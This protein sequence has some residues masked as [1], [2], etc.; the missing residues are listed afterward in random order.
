MLNGLSPWIPKKFVGPKIKPVRLVYISVGCAENI[1][2]QNP[3]AIDN[4][5]EAISVARILIDPFLEK[6]ILPSK[7][8]VYIIRE[9]VSLDTISFKEYINSLTDQKMLVLLEFFTG[10]YA[11]EHNIEGLRNIN[12]VQLGLVPLFEGG[13]Y[14]DITQDH[15]PIFNDDYTEFV[16]ISKM[17]ANDIIN[18]FID[19]ID[20]HTHRLHLLTLFK[21]LKVKYINVLTYKDRRENSTYH[22]DKLKEFL[23]SLE[24]IVGS[25][26][27]NMSVN[28]ML[29]IFIKYLTKNN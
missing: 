2:Q 21:Y 22:S 11:Y 14:F 27:H 9:Y 16:D 6:D 13:C 24:C 25:F 5:S 10:M 15:R 29:D 17:S 18:Y 3:P 4:L 7:S 8:D 12:K 28:A 23:F 26:E 20:G 1:S 19:R